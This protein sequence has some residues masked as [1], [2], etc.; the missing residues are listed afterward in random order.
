MLNADHQAPAH[1][2]T[3]VT[4]ETQQAVLQCKS[5]TKTFT[6]GH[7]NVDVLKSVDLAVLPGEMLAII[8]VSGAGK[9]TLLHILGGLDKPTSGEVLV[10][11]VDIHKLS[12]AQRGVIRNRHLGFVYQFHHLLAEFN[13]LENVCMPLLIRGIHPDQARAK[14]TP[15]LDKVGLAQRY[16]H[17]VGELSGGERQRVAIA[18]ALVTDPVCVLADELTGNLDKKTAEQ[19]FELMLSLNQELKTSFI[20]VTHD[21]SLASRMNRTLSLENGQ[22]LHSITPFNQ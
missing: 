9:S 21:L 7:L 18:R 15:I 3:P 17:R 14:A 22:L 8:G 12:S 5:L 2:I 20:A 19:V 16:Q 4:S 11:G 6:E 10:A 1:F 13:A